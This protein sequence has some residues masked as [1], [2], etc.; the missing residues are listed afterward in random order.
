MRCDSNAVS[1]VSTCHDVCSWIDD[2]Y[3]CHE[4][5]SWLEALTEWSVQRIAEGGLSA[6]PSDHT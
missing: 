2:R 6:S 5:I 1:C 4:W 3:E